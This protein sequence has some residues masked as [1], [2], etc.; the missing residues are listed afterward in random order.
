MGTT[1]V[2]RRHAVAL[3]AMLTSFVILVVIPISAN[4]VHA[5]YPAYDLGLFSQTLLLLQDEINPFNTVRGVHAFADH[6]DPVLF[7]VAPW[8]RFFDP[9]LSVTLIE[10]LF[11]LGGVAVLWLHVRR[12]Q[13]LPNMALTLGGLHLF[14]YAT[15]DALH[16]PVHPTTWATLPVLV[17]GYALLNRQT[18][19]VMAATVLLF[20]CKEEFPFV[21]LLLGAWL[22]RSDRTHARLLLAL[23]AAW[24]VVA[25]GIRSYVLDG[26]TVPHAENLLRRLWRSPWQMLT[27]RD[28][29]TKMAWLFAPWLT[30]WLGC[31]SA[32]PHRSRAMRGVLVAMTPLLLIRL[33]SAKWHVHYIAPVGALLTVATIW[34]LGNCQLRTATMATVFAVTF[35]ISAWRYS[36][37][38]LASYARLLAPEHGRARARLDSIE[39]ARALLATRAPS[40]SIVAQNNLVA[41]VMHQPRG[42]YDF[43]LRRRSYVSADYVFLEQPP[44]GLV[45]GTSHGEI[46]R[47]IARLRSSRAHDVL[48]DDAHIFVARRRQAARGN[49]GAAGTR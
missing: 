35:G 34:G 42:I 31:R 16:Y 20:A 6:F 12:G 21:G 5:Q 37:Q 17:L 1:E 14:S 36:E 45:P 44:G 3:A 8:V 11:V 47:A 19:L 40:S 38:T 43:A 7:L 2:S 23:S 29:V 28:A 10:A 25:F 9:A 15:L 4:V 18:W 33:F 26:N 22:W 46:G 32:A 39:T 27:G 30:L 24:L 49:A 13:L 41:R 48:L